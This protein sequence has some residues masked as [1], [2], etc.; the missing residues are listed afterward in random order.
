M[1]NCALGMMHMANHSSMF[2]PLTLRGGLGRRPAP[3]TT[4]P[5]LSYD[6]S[7]VKFIHFISHVLNLVIRN[8]SV[9][10]FVCL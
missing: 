7:S 3:P 10:L 9:S 6:V 4:F 5:L 1:M 2:C 8:L